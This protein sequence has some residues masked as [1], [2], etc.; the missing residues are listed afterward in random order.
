MYNVEVKC[1]DS[2][3]RLMRL[4]SWLHS[5][6][7]VTLNWVS[8]FPHLYSGDTNRTYLRGWLYSK[9]W[10]QCH[11]HHGNSTQSLAIVWMLRKC[12]FRSPPPV[13]PSLPD[14]CPWASPINSNCIHQFWVWIAAVWPSDTSFNFLLTQVETQGKDLTSR[15]R[16]PCTNSK[17]RER[18]QNCQSR[19][20]T[21][22]EGTFKKAI[23]LIKH[24]FYKEKERPFP[25]NSN[26]T[27]RKEHWTTHLSGKRRRQHLP[28]VALD[29]T[30]PYRF[31]PEHCLPLFLEGYVSFVCCF[32]FPHIFSLSRIRTRIPSSSQ[33]LLRYYLILSMQNRLLAVW[34]WQI[35]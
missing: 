2:G 33:N 8:Q 20:R 26:L 12:A 31:R 29:H 18:P 24:R 23:I 15:N 1:V 27:I 30:E 6:L 3:V 35:T 7:C 13:P 11:T 5:L 25:G 9:Q 19:M 21:E 32:F 34:P 22:V 14:C 10:T 17:A 28:G 4:E 16:P